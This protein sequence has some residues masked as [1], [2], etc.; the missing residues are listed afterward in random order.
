MATDEYQVILTAKN[1]LSKELEKTVVAATRLEAAIKE[2]TTS[3]RPEAAD[4]VE[5]L[6]RALEQ[7]QEDAKRLSRQMDYLDDDIDRVGSTSKETAGDIDKMSRSTKSGKAGFAGF[8]ATLKGGGRAAAAAGAALIGTAIAIKKVADVSWQAANQAAAYEKKVRRTDI[9][10]GRYATRV[11]RWADES[12][13]MWGKS[14]EDVAAMASGVGDI[15]KPLGFTTR[16]ATRLTLSVGDLIP[17]LAEWNTAGMDA[18]QVSYA[19]TAA[20]TGEREMLKSLGIV[21]TEEDVKAKVKAMEAAGKFTDETDKQK[22][23]IA[24]LKLATEGSSDALRSY[25]SNTGSVSRTL[26][27][28]RAVVADVRDAGLEIIAYSI[29]KLADG[30][31]MVGD[32]KT[33]GVLKWIKQNRT[34]LVN[35]AMTIGAG[36]IRMAEFVTRAFSAQL[37]GMATLQLTMEPVFFIMSKVPGAVGEMGQALYGSSAKMF[38]AAAKGD[39]LADSLGTFADKAFAARDK[40]KALNEQLDL[41]KNKKIR[42]EVEV[43]ITTTQAA[44]GAAVRAAERAARRAPG[45]G[46][47]PKDGGD[48]TSPLGVGSLGP[49]GLR[50]AHAQFSAAIGGHRILS[51]VRG[52]NL[53]SPG[54]DH[55]RGRAMDVQG[56]RLG[57]YAA[58]VRRRGG[59]AAMHGDGG[60]RHLHVV[61][62]THRPASGPLQPAVIAPQVTVNNPRHDIDIESAVARGIRIGAR[63]AAERSA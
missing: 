1:Q 49:S 30:L 10:F 6:S 38:D 45:G 11:R 16:E 17:A 12:N 8:A 27:R 35:A 14:V 26:N 20:M 3:T 56:P 59:Y 58:E 62:R 7:A 43:A 34:E 54:S 33:P 21:I 32:A 2:A 29:R 22:A 5:I 4:E 52:H 15:L 31:G 41:I 19:L 60:N 39:E 63:Q 25:E 44:V 53:G 24:T 13:E 36:F 40:T 42:A 37:A 61:P 47:F 9:V 48:T 23:A 46:D 55:L 18:E 51:G 28:F 50:A 57:A